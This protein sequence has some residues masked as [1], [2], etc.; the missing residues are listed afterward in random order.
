MLALAEKTGRQPSLAERASDSAMDVAESV[1]TMGKP[2]FHA[3]L[4]AGLFVEKN[5]FER[6]ESARRVIE[7]GLRARGLTVLSIFEDRPTK[8]PDILRDHPN[9][10]SH[11]LSFQT[12][13]IHTINTVASFTQ[14]IIDHRI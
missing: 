9:S 7:S 14:D 1:L 11:R 10:L 4:M 13:N 8:E 5:G 3:S 12:A 6:A 2:A